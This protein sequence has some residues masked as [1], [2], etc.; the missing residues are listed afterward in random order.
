MKT[1][2]MDLES[3]ML[4]K[5]KKLSCPCIL[6]DGT[7]YKNIS[8]ENILTLSK[9]FGVSGQHVEISAIEA[10]IVPERY[11]RNMKTFSP[12]DQVTLIK[13]QVS[14]V[15]LGGLGGAVIE[16]LAQIG[17]ASCRERV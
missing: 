3:E 15:G 9:N 17:R 8:V 7:S 12:K 16:I 13:S 1:G 6:P 10:G 2:E 4:N 11:A 5:I 14:V